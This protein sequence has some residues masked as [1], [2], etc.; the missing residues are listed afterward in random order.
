MPS[1]RTYRPLR[2]R[3]LTLVRDL[4]VRRERRRTGRRSKAAGGRDP[5][6]PVQRFCRCRPALASGS[7]GAS[8][9]GGLLTPSRCTYDVNSLGGCGVLGTQYL[10]PSPFPFGF[11]SGLALVERTTDQPLQPSDNAPGPAR[12]PMVR[13]AAWGRRAGPRTRATSESGNRRTGSSVRHPAAR[14]STGC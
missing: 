10:I 1:P 3:G 12:R 9:G 2:V 13:R 4:L 7:S 11:R 8:F 14:C 5:G 6:Q